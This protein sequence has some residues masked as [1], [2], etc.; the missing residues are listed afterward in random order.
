MWRAPGRWD[1]HRGSTRGD[2][3]GYA[4]HKHAQGEKGIAM[5]DNHGYVLAPL[6]VAPVNETDM[7]LLPK[8]LHAL[9]QVAKEVGLD[10]RGADVNFDGGFDASAN[11]KAIFL[12]RLIPNV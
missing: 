2:G 6:P 11:R 9:K 5:P 10:C 8:G 1:Q 7:V 12:A 4:G 3:I